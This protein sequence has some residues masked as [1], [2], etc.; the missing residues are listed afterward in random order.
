MNDTV[1]RAATCPCLQ[2]HSST[3]PAGLSYAV[4]C[5]RPDGRTRIP[6]RDETRH[7]CT[8]GRHLGCQGYRRTHVDELFT[9]G[10]A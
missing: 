7:F 5:R 3:S 2:A 6:S 10:L 4:Y 8:T 1:M 9:T